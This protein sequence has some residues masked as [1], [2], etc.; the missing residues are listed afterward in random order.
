ME[1]LKCKSLF[2]I[3]EIIDSIYKNSLSLANSFGRV[4]SHM[5]VIEDVLIVVC[6]GSVEK[7]NEHNERLPVLYTLCMMSQ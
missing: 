2:Y 4:K 1:T 3:Q 5:Q 6:L 7:K